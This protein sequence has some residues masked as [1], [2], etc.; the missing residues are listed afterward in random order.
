[1]FYICKKVLVKF[2][3]KMDSALPKI[4]RQLKFIII[5]TLDKDDTK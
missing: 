4:Y 1:M 5:R 3:I 2:L